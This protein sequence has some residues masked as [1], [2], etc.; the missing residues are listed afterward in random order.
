MSNATAL[1]LTVLPTMSVVPD[2]FDECSEEQVRSGVATQYAGLLRVA[3]R[4]AGN[5]ADA[6]DLVQETCLRAL[7]FADRLRPGSNVAA[8]LHTILRNTA[9]NHFRAKRWR[10]MTVRADDSSAYFCAVPAR[11]SDAMPVTASDFSDRREEFDGVLHDAITSLPD[12]FRD[13]LLLSVLEG[14]RHDDIARILE[15]PRG[16]AMSRLFRARKALRAALTASELSRGP[17]RD[18]AA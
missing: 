18:A 13:V 3:R 17:Q 14:R 12:V 15:I 5:V 9:I 11:G 6:E 7:R 2:T 16:T 1:P 8:W 10:T 4:L